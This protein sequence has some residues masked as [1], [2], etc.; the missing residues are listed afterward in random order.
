MD[1]D[2]ELQNTDIMGGASLEFV[3]FIT[4]SIIDIKHT[5]VHYINVCYNHVYNI[6]KVNHMIV[7]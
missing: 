4:T 1:Y 5:G 6:T 2:S 7:E 3:I